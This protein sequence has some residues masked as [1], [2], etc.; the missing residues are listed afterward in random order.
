M[1]INR[2]LQ[3]PLYPI[4]QLQIPEVKQTRLDNQIPMHYLN[5][6]SQELVKLQISIPA[7]TTYKQKTLQAFYTNKMLKEGSRNF[8]A[9]QIA[10]NIDFYG[11]FF[12]TRLSH[13]R[14]YVN[15]F[16]LN[17]YLPKVLEVVADVLTNPLFA[18]K[19]FAVLQDQEVQ[20][21]NYR[22]KKVKNLAQRE[23]NERLFGDSHPYG[24]TAQ[25]EDYTSIKTTD[26]SNFFNQH[27]QPAHWHLY[28]SGLVTPQVLE[29]VNEHLGHL[30]GKVS[31]PVMEKI[32]E[33]ETQSGSFFTEQKD[34][35]QTALKMGML[36]ISRQHEDFAALSLT[37]TIFGGFFGSRLMQNIREDKGYTY[38]IYSSIQNL[39]HANIFSISS[40]VG[41]EVAQNT[42]HEIYIEIDRMKN[43]LVD[44]DELQ[45]VKNYMAGSLLRSLN[46]PFALGE[47]MR[48][49]SE[50][51]LPA[52]YYIQ[53]IKRVQ[54]VTALEVRE[55]AQRYFNQES[56]TVVLAGSKQ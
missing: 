29:T 1:T 24:K 23:F 25:P 53:Y 19:E 52:D 28:L 6:G 36:T 42:L 9:T 46:G 27:Y 37:E 13:D 11:A 32:P 41:S 10:E 18:Q 38:G 51:Q 34:A 54:Q 30:S 4:S 21:F 40:E 3:P 16:S 5:L 50:E 7:G 43:E 56:F 44:D 55:M 49:V 22:M 26:L 31:S 48:M 45:L 8:S 39:K 47:M 14:A 12:E 20:A 33:P 17:K 35:M 2:T 15:I